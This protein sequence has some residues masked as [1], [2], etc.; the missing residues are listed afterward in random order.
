MFQKILFHNLLNSIPIIIIDLNDIY[1]K[2]NTIIN[3]EFISFS[4]D[5]KNKNRFFLILSFLS[6]ISLI[7]KI[8]KTLMLLSKDE[9]VRSFLDKYL[10]K[11]F[12]CNVKEILKKY[13]DKMDLIIKLNQSYK[14][15]NFIKQVYDYIKNFF[16]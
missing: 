9:Q 13:K 15:I 6:I 4:Y 14:I 7:I 11:I 3:I 10:P 2:I 8:L 16:L 1:Q 12:Y 5:N